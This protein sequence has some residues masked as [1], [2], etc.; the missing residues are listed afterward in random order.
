[1]FRTSRN[2]AG[3]NGHPS[4]WPF[5]LLRRMTLWAALLGGGVGAVVSLV[6]GSPVIMLTAAMWAAFV[7]LSLGLIPA[8]LLTLLDVAFA[9]RRRR[10]RRYEVRPSDVRPGAQGLGSWTI[11]GGWVGAMIG[12]GYAMVYLNAFAPNARFDDVLSISI[13]T[14]IGAGATTGA[15]SAIKLNIVDH[16]SPAD[17]LTQVLKRGAFLWAT[18]GVGLGVGAYVLQTLSVWDLIPTYETSLLPAA[19]LAAMGAG[20]VPQLAATAPIDPATIPPPTPSFEDPVPTA[21]SPGPSNPEGGSGEGALGAWT[22]APP[23]QI[24]QNQ[25]ARSSADPIDMMPMEVANG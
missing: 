15:L 7:V 5:Y 2:R 6:G 24:P 20:V 3:V 12:A 8:A 13:I 14:G 17:T 16:Y 21:P 18:A 11:T 22:T 19:L 10:H 9:G 1:M 4:L 25:Q 23:P